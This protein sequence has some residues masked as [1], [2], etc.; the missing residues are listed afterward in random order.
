[1]TDDTTLVVLQKLSDGYNFVTLTYTHFSLSYLPL[2]VDKNDFC[3]ELSINTSNLFEL[4]PENLSEAAKF[5]YED[6]T[7]Y[8]I[9]IPPNYELIASYNFNKEK[10]NSNDG[11]EE[12][13]ESYLNRS[14]IKSMNLTSL[15]SLYKKSHDTEKHVVINGVRVY[16]VY[17]QI[18][19]K[20]YE[21]LKA[22]TLKITKL[23]FSMF[24]ANYKTRPRFLVGTKLIRMKNNG[25]NRTDKEKSKKPASS[26]VSKASTSGTSA[27]GASGAS[28][29][30]ASF[31]KLVDDLKDD[32]NK[33]K[34]SIS[35]KNAQKHNAI[36]RF[37]RTNNIVY[38]R[39]IDG[40]Q[41]DASEFLNGT[42]EFDNRIQMESRFTETVT[43]VCYDKDTKYIL[44]E[45]DFPP[46]RSVVATHSILMVDSHLLEKEINI[47][48]H[49][50]KIGEKLKKSQ[51]RAGCNRLYVDSDFNDVDQDEMRN[52]LGRNQ[53]LQSHDMNSLRTRR[54]SVITNLGNFLIVQLKRM[55]IVQNE[56]TKE[57][58][59]NKIAAKNVLINIEE[60]FEHEGNNFIL[61]AMIFH[62]GSNCNS[63]HYIA[64]VKTNSGWYS[65]N[66]SVVR[67]LKNDDSKYRM[68][69]QKTGEKPYVLMYQRDTVAPM[70]YTVKGLPNIGNSC[71]VNASLQMLM[72]IIQSLINEL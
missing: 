15:E 54:N 11:N 51:R 64:H 24:V 50:F 9:E 41:E 46:F 23:N 58:K 71:Y 45:T 59:P 33:S 35:R 25:E 31:E 60:E 53:Y 43:D 27:S 42:L 30:S 40:V 61:C 14:S 52:M 13:K 34:E 66:D 62:S 56:K 44:D 69:G 22:K 37:I 49:M 3:Y 48:T 17:K 67:K 47:P 28:G 8:V 6:F 18:L 38:S 39:F 63:G 2:S 72:P 20:T 4:N 19:R 32:Y 70:N 7:V 36:R 16:S 21:F 12:E 1:M 10:I 68:L 29:T 57:L 5:K 65:A 55:I 26:V